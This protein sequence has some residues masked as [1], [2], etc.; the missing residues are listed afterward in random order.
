M[1]FSTHGI[2]PCGM[3]QA[4]VQFSVARAGLGGSDTDSH[5]DPLPSIPS[6]V[7]GWAQMATASTGART[8]SKKN[9][10]SV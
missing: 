8:L 9:G 7:I 10:P 4:G 6:R 3:R 2:T 1:A 5:L